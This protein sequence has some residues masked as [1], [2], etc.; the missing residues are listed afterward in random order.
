[1]IFQDYLYKVHNTKDHRTRWRCTKEAKSGCKGACFTQGSNL[2]IRK[3]HNHP[4]EKIDDSYKINARPVKILNKII[5]EQILIL[6]SYEYNC[7]I[8][9][10]NRTRWRCKNQNKTKC[11]ASLYTSGNVV[12]VKNQHNHKPHMIRSDA[13]L[14]PQHVRIVKHRYYCDD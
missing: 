14:V 13:I 12:K 6:D 5:K 2:F 4:P 10:A 3:A 11:S 8:K 9:E 7:H 1:M